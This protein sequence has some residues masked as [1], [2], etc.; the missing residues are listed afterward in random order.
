M[1]KKDSFR[2]SYRMFVDCAH[3]LFVECHRLNDENKVL[4]NVADTKV[5]R[6]CP[7]CNKP[8]VWLD[9][10][11]SRYVYLL[12]GRDGHGRWIYDVKENV[13]EQT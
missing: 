9:T 10:F 5:P 4:R 13:W 11:Y 8:V 7:V 6:N 12:C 2:Q 1:K 3:D